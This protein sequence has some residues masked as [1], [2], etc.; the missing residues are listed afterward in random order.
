M[1]HRGSLFSVTGV[2]GAFAG[3]AAISRAQRLEQVQG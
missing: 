1:K 2:R 3:S